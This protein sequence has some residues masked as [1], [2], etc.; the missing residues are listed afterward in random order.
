[1]ASVVLDENTLAKG[2]EGRGLGNEGSTWEKMRDKGG[3]KW[4]RS[5][6]SG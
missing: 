1:M 4:Q 5:K 3:E 2:G 6:M